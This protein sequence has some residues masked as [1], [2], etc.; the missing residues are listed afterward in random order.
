MRHLLFA[1][2][3]SIVASA[4]AAVLALGSGAPQALAE[5]GSKTAAT[6]LSPTGLQLEYPARSLR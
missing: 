4:L 5:K 3:A 1:F 2:R 6:R